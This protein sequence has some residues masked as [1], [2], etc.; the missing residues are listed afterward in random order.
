MRDIKDYAESYIE[1]KD[2]YKG[3]D[4][5][6]DRKVKNE[7]R[8]WGLIWFQVFQELKIRSTSKVI[9]GA[10]EYQRFF[11]KAVNAVWASRASNQD[12]DLTEDLQKFNDLIKVRQEDRVAEQEKKEKEREKDRARRRARQRRRDDETSQATT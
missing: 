12:G 3:K 7:H 11:A 5:G 8:I 6:K 2:E 9:F 10:L 1:L 4:E